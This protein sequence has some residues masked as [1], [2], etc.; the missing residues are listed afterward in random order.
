MHAKHARKVPMRR[1]HGVTAA[2]F[3]GLGVLTLLTVGKLL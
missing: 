1:V 2:I 3:A